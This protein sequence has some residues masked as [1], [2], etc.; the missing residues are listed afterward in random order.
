VGWGVGS[1]DEQTMRWFI[2]VV[3]LLLDPAA[4]LLLL[5]ASKLTC[6]VTPRVAWVVQWCNGDTAA[7][8]Q[9]IC[10]LAVYLLFG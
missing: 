6:T 3:A 5:A 10:I 1:T 9:G 8:D 7:R 2:L 4:G